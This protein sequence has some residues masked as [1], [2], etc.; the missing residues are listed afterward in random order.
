MLF[1]LAFLYP[2]EVLLI[3]DSSILVNSLV[4][5]TEENVFERKCWALA[6]RLSDC[7][8]QCATM[9]NSL[10]KGSLQKYIYFPALVDTQWKSP[11]SQDLLSSLLSSAI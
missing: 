5:F 11:I 10:L 1:G 3:N 4:M 7:L 6:S 2:W 8:C 9:P